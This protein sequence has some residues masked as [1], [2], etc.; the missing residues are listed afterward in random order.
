MRVNACRWPAAVRA[1][2]TLQVALGLIWLADGLL[3]FQPFMFGRGFVTKIIAPNAIG[4]PAV[5]AAPVTFAAHL[6]EPRVA[7]FNAV[8][9]TTQVLIGL[10]LLYRPT[11][12]PALLVSFGWALNVWW[13]GEGLGG[14][15]TSTASPLTGAPG[16]ALLY[17]FAGLL[18]WPSAHQQKR[19][20]STAGPLGQHGA[21]IAW[22]M[23]WIYLAALW[24][25]PANTAPNAV[26]EAITDAPSGSRWLS[27]IHTTFAA[28]TAG[29][30]HAIAIVAAILSTAIGLAVLF[31]YGAKPILAA[32]SLIAL[33]FFVIGQGMGGILTGTGTDL[34]SGPLLILVAAWFYPLEDPTRPDHRGEATSDFAPISRA[35][36]SR[37]TAPARW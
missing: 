17:V 37:S 12:K 34:G 27:D 9:A 5:V 18:I 6:I 16:P 22:A 24:L 11:V 29:H 10:G 30:G 26:R 25:S 31:D 15:A 28:A 33:L 1:R 19:S 21:R 4:Q 13:I 8:A 7:L 3:Q 36:S 14:L 32:S 2:R 20:A 23:L 35:A